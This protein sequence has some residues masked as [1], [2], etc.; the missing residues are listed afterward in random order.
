MHQE[1]HENGYDAVEVALHPET[2]SLGVEDHELGN[3]S[4]EVSYVEDSM[5]MAEVASAHDH[6]EVPHSLVSQ[7]WVEAPEDLVGFRSPEPVD[8]TLT[9]R[10]EDDVTPE[11]SHEVSIDTVEEEPKPEGA[12]DDIADIVGLLESTSFTSK[13]ILQ[14]HEGIATNPRTPGLDKEGQRIGEIPDEE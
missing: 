13:H 1:H 5:E 6:E 2:E 9:L 3:D 11:L 12:K 4:L 8:P 10:D 7:E 14:G